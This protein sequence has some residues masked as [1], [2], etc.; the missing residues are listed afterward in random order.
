MLPFIGT[1]ETMRKVSWDCLLSYMGSRY[2]VPWAYAGK[3][4]WLRTSQGRILI[5]RNQKGEE[6][7]RHAL[8][9]KKGATVIDRTHYEGLRQRVA[10]TRRQSDQS[11]EGR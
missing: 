3:Q 5:V 4:V 7:A 11:L 9:P 10:K 1:N 6:I 8:A 2:S